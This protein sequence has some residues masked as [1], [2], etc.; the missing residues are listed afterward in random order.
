[1]DFTATLPEDCLLL[2]FG[3]VPLQHRLT[4]VPLV[5]RRWAQ[6]Q[7]QVR[8]AATS[9]TLISGS[10][11][12]DYQLRS[13]FYL[14]D[15]QWSIY[16]DDNILLFSQL[17]PQIVERLLVE[18]PKI[19]RLIIVQLS[20]P[21][22]CTALHDELC[23]V[24]EH[25]ARQ[26]TR[27]DFHYL[28]HNGCFGGWGPEV[29]DEENPRRP[30][31]SVNFQRLISLINYGMPKL[32]HLLLNSDRTI[33]DAH[34]RSVF[35]G[36]SPP[37]GSV[38][39]PVLQQLASFSFRTGDHEDVLLG[40]LKK[41]AGG[42]QSALKLRL[43]VHWLSSATFD[44]HL[45]N[46]HP[47]MKFQLW[48]ADGQTLLWLNR[49]DYLFVKHIELDALIPLLPAL[50]SLQYLHLELFDGQNNL[51]PLFTALSASL[52]LLNRFHL[53]LGMTL[54]GN[55]VPEDPPPLPPLPSVTS[56]LLQWP[57][58]DPAHF[59]AV[60]QPARVF[61]ALQKLTIWEERFEG[62][63]FYSS[64][65]DCASRNQQNQR[66]FGWIEYGPPFP[67]CIRPALKTSLMQYPPGAAPLI[68]LNTENGRE[69]FT[70]EEL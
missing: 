41:F 42:E 39:L 18:L 49:L 15:H 16:D 48:K 37:L 46:E 40:S 30:T 36:E 33:F 65:C 45:G 43:G 20:Y 60:L 66:N 47:A 13:P 25:Y 44:P 8:K 14:V 24:M 63:A 61:S 59:G 67:L 69:W 56:L 31:L 28:Y 3:R 27:F 4:T 55:Q 23:S 50:A 32:R 12:S 9:L 68:N 10:S 21:N 35:A 58:E 70:V 1:M 57:F 52:P 22:N 53:N 17:T 2:I 7:P 54:M 38:C 29:E 11:L 51:L 34:W 19:C 64:E 5:C 62:C 26:L 6:L